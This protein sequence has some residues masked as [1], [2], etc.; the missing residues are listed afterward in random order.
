MLEHSTKTHTIPTSR[1]TP[2]VLPQLRNANDEQ[3]ARLQGEA[4]PAKWLRDAVSI[5]TTWVRKTSIPLPENENVLWDL[6]DIKTYWADFIRVRELQYAHSPPPPTFDNVARKAEIKD[7]IARLLLEGL[8]RLLRD[9]VAFLQTIEEKDVD[10][11]LA[12]TRA[13]VNSFEDFW[14]QAEEAIRRGEQQLLPDDE[15]MEYGVETNFWSSSHLS[16][17][18]S[19]LHIPPSL[20]FLTP[21]YSSLGSNFARI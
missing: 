1:D 19:L 11:A 12:A 5:V 17:P 7:A 13:L 6:G 15:H 14:K 18:I 20:P 4:K 9:S 16:F 2:P 3:L 8:E 21:P 10:L